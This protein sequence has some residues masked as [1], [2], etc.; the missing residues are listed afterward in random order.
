VE[1][2][3]FGFI[4]LTLLIVPN[5]NTQYFYFVSLLTFTSNLFI[6]VCAGMMMCSTRNQF[7]CANKLRLIRLV[8]ATPREGLGDRGAKAILFFGAPG[9]F[10][11]Q[12]LVAC[13]K[14]VKVR[15]SYVQC[16]LKISSF[17]VPLRFYD[18]LSLDIQQ[19]LKRFLHSLNI[20]IRLRTG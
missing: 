12:Y 1:E 11:L 15:P 5:N 10:D 9:R 7:A 17:V 13:F 8:P 3:L 14:S 16:P 20:S 6:L 2:C 18:C 19:K 4:N